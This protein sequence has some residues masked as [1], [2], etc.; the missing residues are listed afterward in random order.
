MVAAGVGDRFDRS[1]EPV[2][3]PELRWTAFAGIIAAGNAGAGIE[4]ALDATAIGASSSM[5][6]PSTPP[7]AIEST[8]WPL[9][10]E[11]GAGFGLPLCFSFGEV[12]A[13]RDVES[14]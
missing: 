3:S 13:L 4:T 5:S 1:A 10:R 14:F 12:E 9:E 2:C 7:I 8:S 6:N 11:F